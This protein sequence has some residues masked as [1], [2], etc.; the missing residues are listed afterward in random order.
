M[1]SSERSIMSSGMSGFCCCALLKAHL[2]RPFLL[3]TS[4]RGFTH[5]LHGISMA[6]EPPSCHPV[7]GF[8]P[9]STAACLVYALFMSCADSDWD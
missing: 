4:S 2:C 8:E 9:Y 7:P 3:S 1:A 5:V 6:D